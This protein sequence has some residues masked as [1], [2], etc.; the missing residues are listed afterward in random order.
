MHAS[1]LSGTPV[2]TMQYILKYLGQALIQVI[3]ISFAL[4]NSDD[5]LQSSKKEVHFDFIQF[6]LKI[7]ILLYP[8]GTLCTGCRY[9]GRGQLSSLSILT[10]FD[11]YIPWVVWN[12]EVDFKSNQS[13]PGTFVLAYGSISQNTGVICAP[14]VLQYFPVI[15]KTKKDSHVS[16]NAALKRKHDLS[17]KW[18]CPVVARFTVLQIKFRSGAWPI[19]SD[20]PLSV[21]KVFSCVK[22]CVWQIH[23]SL[24]LQFQCK[25]HDM[26]HQK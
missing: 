26:I 8:S 14:G 7:V 11:L 17:P 23:I 5:D 15:Y 3:S 4:I 10:G 6:R 22:D 25:G 9:D 19:A 24:K 1:W 16:I 20:F 13:P 21:T 12:N 2:L 18:D